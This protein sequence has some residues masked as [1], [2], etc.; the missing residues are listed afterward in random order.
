M[1]IHKIAGHKTTISSSTDAFNKNWLYVSTFCGTIFSIMASG[2]LDWNKR[3]DIKLKVRQSKYLGNKEMTPD[4]NPQ[5]FVFLHFWV[6]ESTHLYDSQY[7]LSMK[8]L[9]YIKKNISNGHTIDQR[10]FPMKLESWK[11]RNKS[12][13]FKFNITSSELSVS[14]SGVHVLMENP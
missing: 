6:Y 3:Q 13:S 10:P 5:T 14:E 1:D 4:K 2:N 11:W 8:N 12:L 7:H 9:F